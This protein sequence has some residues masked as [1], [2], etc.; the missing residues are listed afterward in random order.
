MPSRPAV[1]V[2][3]PSTA[4]TSDHEIVCLGH[5]KLL[6]ARLVARQSPRDCSIGP[7][8]S[9][10]PMKRNYPRSNRRQ[11]GTVSDGLTILPADRRIR[12]GHPPASP[13]LSPV[14]ALVTRATIVQMSLIR[15]N[16]MSGAPLSHGRTVAPLLSQSSS[17][18]RTLD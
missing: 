2:E 11:A 9:A 6:W 14:L 5:F 15:N 1:I 17:F 8:M 4:L 13:G 10:S 18:R 7:R 16:P 12:N 3:P